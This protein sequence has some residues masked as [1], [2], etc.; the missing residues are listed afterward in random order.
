MDNVPVLAITGRT[1]SDLIGS[2]YQ[3]DLLGPF[4]AVAGFNQ[5][6]MSASHPRMCVDLACKFAIEN[7]DVAHISI[8]I[9]VQEEE[10]AKVQI[11]E[12]KVPGSTSDILPAVSVPDYSALVEAL[13]S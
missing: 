1:Y 7:R 3:G 5:L 4:Y 2:R 9:D 8:P 10:S 11:T 13:Q 6:V 12:H